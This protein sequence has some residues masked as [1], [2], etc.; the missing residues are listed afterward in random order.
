MTMHSEDRREWTDQIPRLHD[1]GDT[2]GQP[3]R[4]YVLVDVRSEFK[5]ER[6][7]GFTRIPGSPVFQL[8]GPRGQAH[9]V[10]VQRGEPA[11]GVNPMASA[12]PCW[13]D[14]LLLEA[15]G[16]V[17][18]AIIPEPEA[19]ALA[20]ASQPLTQDDVAI[21]NTIEKVMSEA[22]PKK[23]LGQAPSAGK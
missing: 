2:G 12:Q 4:E 17:T 7:G 19:T 22:P 23:A 11:M 6:E 15:T 10:V 20:V 9:F 21:V 18:E 14:N 1:L 13:I 8:N 3:G 16:L 5:A